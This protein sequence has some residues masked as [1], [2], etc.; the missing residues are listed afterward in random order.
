MAV[1]ILLVHERAARVVNERCAQWAEP[2]EKKT[3]RGG[4]HCGQLAQGEKPAALQLAI[5][6][7]HTNFYELLRSVIF[8]CCRGRATR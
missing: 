1:V 4:E 6:G 5:N 3:L 2:V 8:V 7:W